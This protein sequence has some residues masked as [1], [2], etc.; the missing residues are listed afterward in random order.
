M[1]AF[2]LGSG[3]SRA[4]S[5]SMPTVRELMPELMTF[6]ERERPQHSRLEISPFIEDL[7][8]T[9][10]YLATPQPFLTDAENEEN[11]ALFSRISE[12]LARKIFDAQS[13]ATGSSCPEWLS[14]LV[15]KWDRDNAAI[16][17]LNYDTLVEAVLTSGVIPETGKRVLPFHAYPFPLPFDASRTGGSV[18]GPDPRATFCLYKLHG[19]VNWFYSGERGSIGDPLYQVPE[20]SPWGR[21][22]PPKFDEFLGRNPGLVPFVIP[23]TPSKSPYFE[24]AMFREIWRRA[25]AALNSADTLYV[26]GYSFAAADL[27]VQ[28][29]VASTVAPGQRVTVVNPDPNV[30]ARCRAIF[31]NT[32]NLTELSDPDCLPDFAEKY[33]SDKSMDVR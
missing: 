22:R 12:W 9:L 25:R 14:Q 10:G 11:H 21:E 24:N 7:E 18:W 19:S 8:A 26:I 2:L 27:Q 6:A 15:R 32:G 17:T 33:C 31:L 5:D 4:I 28:A 23:P 16:V 3:F 13:H 29:L 1:D 30:A 20:V